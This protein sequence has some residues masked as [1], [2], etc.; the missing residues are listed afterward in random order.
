MATDHK[1]T[2]GEVVAFWLAGQALQARRGQTLGTALS[3]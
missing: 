1:I 2:P 3:L